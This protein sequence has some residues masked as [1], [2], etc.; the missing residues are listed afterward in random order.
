MGIQGLAEPLIDPLVDEN[1]HLRFLDTSS[2]GFLENA[3]G[4]FAGSHGRAGE[5]LLKGF[6]ALQVVKQDLD[7]NPRPAKYGN[8]ARS[9]MRTATE[10]WKLPKKRQLLAVDPAADGEGQEADSDDQ[11]G[12][13]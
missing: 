5:E 1:S 12:D 8:A 13:G 7:G 9:L 4:L 11:A 6:A 3:N 10:C 2:L